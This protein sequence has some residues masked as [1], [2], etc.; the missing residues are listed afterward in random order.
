MPQT[1]S[2]VNGGA[3]EGAPGCS[4]GESPDGQPRRYS[5][6]ASENSGA[7]CAIQR[8]RSQATIWTTVATAE[9]QASILRPANMFAPRAAWSVPT[10][11]AAFSFRSSVRE[12]PEPVHV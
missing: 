6:G 5:Q 10:F 9:S 3:P 7:L 4:E 2:G 8:E 11:Q 12:R 1:Y